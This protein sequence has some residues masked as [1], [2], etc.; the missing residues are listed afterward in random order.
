MRGVSSEGAR[1]L[2][3]RPGALAADR[4]PNA[5]IRTYIILIPQY[6]SHPYAYITGA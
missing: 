4:P 5:Y 3:S 6:I 1:A 2:L